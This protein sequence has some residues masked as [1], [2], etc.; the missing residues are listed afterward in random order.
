METNSG[1]GRLRSS[2]QEWRGFVSE[3]LASGRDCKSFCRD[4]GKRPTRP[5]FAPDYLS[6]F[7][8]NAKPYGQ[9]RS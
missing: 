5:P 3:F 6:S 9:K 8:D 2:K 4:K 1:S 7:A